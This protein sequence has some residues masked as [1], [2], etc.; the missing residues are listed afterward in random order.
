MKLSLKVA[1]TAL[2]STFLISSPVFAKPDAKGKMMKNSIEENKKTMKRIY[3]EVFT[4]QKFEVL[5]ELVAPNA[6]DHD[7]EI[8]PEMV[9]PGQKVTD[10]L[11]EY[12]K[13][14]HAA[15]PDFKVTANDIIVE[16][17]KI[18]ARYTMTG[19]HKGTFMGIPASGKKLNLTGIDIVRI[20]D[21]KAVEHWGAS[22]MMIMMKQLGAMPPS[23]PAHSEK[24][25]K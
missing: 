17:D 20:K 8:Y 11:K 1:A 12:I 22:D 3:D 2:I 21:G 25:G 6:V 18:V 5:D 19:T 16:G 14:S 4:K 7:F 15:F 10:A 24:K 23:P 13:M 9:K